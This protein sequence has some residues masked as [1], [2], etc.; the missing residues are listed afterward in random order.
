MGPQAMSGGR[1]QFLASNLA[2]NGSS[3]LRNHHLCHVTINQHMH[4]PS[5]DPRGRMGVRHLAALFAVCAAIA[6]TQ[7]HASSE[8]LLDW[9]AVEEVLNNAISSKVFPGCVAAGKSRQCG[10]CAGSRTRSPSHLGCCTVRVPAGQIYLRAF[11]KLTYGDYFPPASPQHNPEV[12]VDTMYDL[13]RCVRTPGWDISCSHTQL[14][15]TCIHV[16]P[17]EGD[18]HNVSGSAAGATRVP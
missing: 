14:M 11:G 17:D 3:L 10:T 9:S 12:T 2:V 16:Q 13:A 5:P 1:S 18:Q 15:C 6:S 4:A 7:T 8:S